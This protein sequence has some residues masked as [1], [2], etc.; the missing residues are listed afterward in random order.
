MK[1]LVTLLLIPIFFLS[2]SQDATENGPKGHKVAK[3]SIEQFVDNIRIFGGSFFPDEKSMLVTSNQTGIMNAY[4][5]SLPSGELAPLT[6]SDSTSIF[7]VTAFPNDNRIIISKDVGG[8][9]NEISHL[10]IVEEDGSMQDIIKSP[11]ARGNFFRW[12]QGNDA[13]F[14]TSTERDPRFADVYKMT[15]DGYQS[16]MVYQNDEGMDVGAI[17]DDENYFALIRA[18]TT[19]ANEMY[20]FNVKTGE[21]TAISPP[22]SKYSYSPQYFDHSGKHLYFLTNEG[23]EFTYLKRYNLEDGT[24]EKTQEYSWDITSVYES[25]NG[26]YQILGVNEDAQTV[27]KIFDLKNEGK[28]VVFPAELNGEISAISVSRSEK[29]M[30]FSVSNAK[31]P[32]NMYLYNIEN[33][34][35]TQLTQTLNPEI[36][37]DDLVEGRVIRYPSFDGLEIP[38]ILYKPHEASASNQ[39]PALV[40][41]HGGPGGQSRIG[42]SPLTQYLANHGYA[43]LAVNNRG[44]SGYGKSFNEMDNRNHGEGDLD[45]CVWSKKYLASL[46]YIDTSKIGILGGSYGGFMT[47]A[48]MAFRPEEFKVGV[49]I[50]GV[51]NWMRTLR[52]IPPWWA[53]FKDALYEEMGDPYSEDSV[54][55][56]N[57][58][59]L[60]HADKIQNPVMVLQGANDP[61]VLQPESD[62][63][64]EAVRKNN[65]PVEYVLF[66]DEG[67]G[68]QKKE[69]EIEGYGKIL[70]FLDEYLK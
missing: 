47:M 26:H 10:F 24:Q 44:S 66:Q 59:P 34:D 52:S 36:K 33:G 1:K 53:S 49:D 31:A 17:S 54:R 12:A 13:F 57:I 8:D 21:K 37:E 67:H 39:V 70:K 41:V 11:G 22:N 15:L 51:T 68:F 58:S 63:I 3:Y 48:A 29:W 45:D 19:S 46:G 28:D 7:G 40:W 23:G 65:V 64:V 14:Y 4:R 69:N 32:S 38:S 25:Y 20:L 50:F 60:F 2:C 35:L 5:M 18:I 9:G 42:Y 55:L 56:Y 62:E 61:R 6:N 16:E 43:I 27:V 30:R